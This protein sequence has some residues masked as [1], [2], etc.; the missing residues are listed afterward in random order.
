MHASKNKDERKKCADDKEK[1]RKKDKKN[2]QSIVKVK[3]KDERTCERK[4][5]RDENSE[6]SK[7]MC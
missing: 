5:K 3:C 2:R 4:E 1:Y 6:E 7:T